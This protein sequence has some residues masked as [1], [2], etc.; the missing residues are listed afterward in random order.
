MNNFYKEYEMLSAYIDGELN[1]KEVNY[2]EDKIAVSKDLQIK[3]AEL[4]RLKEL[5]QSSFQKVAD[6]PYFE[7]KV[8]AGITSENASRFKFGKWIPVAGVTVATIILMLFL[9]S[10]PNF[11][12]SIIEEQKSKLAGLYTENLK[13]LFITAG[14]TNEDVFNFALYRKLP[15][16]KERGQYL[17]LGANEDGTEFFEIKAASLREDKNEFEN[18][19]SALELNHKQKK[20]IDSILESYVEDIKTQVLVNENKTVAISPKL[21]NYN[22]AI[23]ADIMAFAK[24]ANREQYVKIVPAEYSKLERSK[25][26]EIAHFVK[27]AEDSDYIFVTPDTIFIERFTFDKEQFADDMKKIQ[28]D[29]KKNL[30]EVEKELKEKDIVLRLD[31]NII[32]LQ[33][34]GGWDKNFE[35]FIDTN[36]CR[37][38]VPNFSVNLSDIHLP[39]LEVLEEQIAAATQN[40]KSFTIRIPGDVQVKKNFKYKYERG[41]SSGK[42]KYDISVPLSPE[43]FFKDSLLFNNEIFKLKADSLSREWKFMFDDSIIFNQKDF[44]LQMKEFQKEMQKLREEMLRLQKDL[45]EEPSKIKEAE[46]IEI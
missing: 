33:T 6:S 37:V 21:W 25:L 43:A 22:K 32:K 18:F 17:Q 16:D 8:L 23:F 29:I 39:N 34:K 42:F 27:N 30:L 7:T 44:K 40:L 24:D 15:L 14:L 19:I 31:D 12:D 4:K 13:P 36:V 35:I 46:S 45:K 2:I 11:F 20:Q 41:D 28:V 1:E 38:R 3:L 5:S 9:K 10:N 26:M